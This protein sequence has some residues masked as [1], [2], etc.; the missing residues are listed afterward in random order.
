[1]LPSHNDIIYFVEVARSE[2]LSRA[3][4]RLGVS[5][6]S[7]SVSMKRLEED[8]G[9]QLLVRSK[10]GVRLTRAG[11]RLLRQS[12]NLLNQWQDLKTEI[13][14]DEKS[15]VG[16]YSLGCHSS[17]ALYTLPLFA[18]K[19]V[20][21]NPGLE[22]SLHHDLSRKINEAVVNFKLDFGIVINPV[23]H[24][25]LIIK[26][27]C[28]DTVG[29]W[30]APKNPN[31]DVLICDHNLLQTQSLLKKIKSSKTPFKRHISSLDLEVVAAL[32]AS[33]AGCGILPSRVAQR[34]KSYGLKPL[35]GSWPSFQD[36]VALVYRADTQ[37]T[38]AARQ[39]A[40]YIFEELKANC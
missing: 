26:P 33:G 35:P 6:P 19:L 1:M 22:L 29:F 13:T 17:V 15:L 24:P 3:A 39:L 40:R 10:S 27:I 16:N 12:Q 28:T 11:H 8:I 25:D 14:K 38:P 2:N 31:K 23:H 9:A 21:D 5:Q 4:E 20:K 18:N 34:V 30:T 37:T 7:L 32:T 36:K